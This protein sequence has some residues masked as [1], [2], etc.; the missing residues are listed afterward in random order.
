[1]GGQEGGESKQGRSDLPPTPTVPCKVLANSVARCAR[2]RDFGAMK[3]SFVMQQSLQLFHCGVC[4]EP[5][6]CSTWMLST[7]KCAVCAV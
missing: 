1:M 7:R 2:R 5:A 4:S 3:L 6:S